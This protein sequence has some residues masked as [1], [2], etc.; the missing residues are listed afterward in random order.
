MNRR[1]MLQCALLVAI[2]PIGARAEHTRFWR[3]SDYADF[4]RGTATGVAVRSDGKIT[5]APRFESFADPSLSFLWSLKL[6][7]Q[8]RLYAAGGSD[9]KVLRFDATGKPTTVFQ[10]AE[11]AAQAIAFDAKGNLYVAT[12]PDGKVYK[13]MPDGAKSVFFDRK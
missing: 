2:F 10:A 4:A 6:D 8:G 13:V 9:A 1:R 11:L 3:Q 7:S 12:S 5:P